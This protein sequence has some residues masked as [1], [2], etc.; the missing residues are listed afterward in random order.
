MYGENVYVDKEGVMPMIREVCGLVVFIGRYRKNPD[1]SYDFYR[2]G[3]EK[4][5]IPML[6]PLTVKLA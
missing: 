3:E 2:D 1:G 5:T 6:P 4:N